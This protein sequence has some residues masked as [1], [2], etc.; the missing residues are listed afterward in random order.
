MA[1]SPR[2]WYGDETLGSSVAEDTLWDF[3]H[4]DC[5]NEAVWDDQLDREALAGLLNIARPQDLGHRCEMD[6]D[7]EISTDSFMLAYA[8]FSG[9]QMAFA[10]NWRDEWFDVAV[11]IAG[12]SDHFERLAQSLGNTNRTPEKSEDKV[13][14][15]TL[16]EMHR[17]FKETS[18]SLWEWERVFRL[19]NPDVRK[20][21]LVPP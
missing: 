3:M 16:P 1:R 7:P 19:K 17:I 11:D 5:G 15:I 13:Q 9:K 8:P 4:L 2:E 21:A 20:I 12:S 18:P 6:E 10:E 14:I